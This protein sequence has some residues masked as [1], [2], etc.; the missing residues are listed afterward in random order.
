MTLRPTPVVMVSSL[1]QS[2]S[3]AT[4]RALELGA[5]DYVAKPHGSDGLGFQRVAE[6]LI[7]KIKLASTARV[8]ALH[9]PSGPPGILAAPRRAGSKTFIAIGASTGGVERIRDILQVMP[10]NCPPI[11][12]TQH[13]GPSY[14]ASFAD[15]LDR[16][17]QPSV[18]LATHGARLQQGVVFIAPGDVHLAVGRDSLGYLCQLQDTPAVSGHRPSVDVLFHSVAKAAGPNAVGAILSGMGRDGASGMAAMRANGAHTVG[19]QE[20][21]CVVYGMPK[22]AK[23]AGGVALELP[24][25]QIAPELLRAIDAIADRPR[26]N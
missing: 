23:E 5:V 2:G 6:D 12:I 11:V 19:E 1:T 16:L 3:D 21:S 18:R 7:I 15:R 9:R 20:N 26:A 13:M 22:T 24:L 8:R 10:A 14:L 17:S 4:I 25:A